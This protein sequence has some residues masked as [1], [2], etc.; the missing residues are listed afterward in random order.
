MQ[1]HATPVPA[2]GKLSERN[3]SY[4]ESIASNKKK[5]RRIGVFSKMGGKVQYKL[6]FTVGGLGLQ[7]CKTLLDAYELDHDWD[8]VRQRVF[9]DKS[10]QVRTES[11]A[12]RLIREY[13]SRLKNLNDEEIQTFRDGTRADQIAILSLS[14]CR[15]YALIGDFA[16]EVM[17]ERALSSQME[18]HATDFERFIDDK[19][20][21]HPGEL[22]PRVGFV[23]TT[24]T[25][26]V[27]RVFEFYNRRGTAV[28]YTKEG[29]YALKWTRLSCKS[30]KANEVRLQLHA[31]AYNLA[32]FLRSL[33]LPTSIADW[34]LMSLRDRMIKIGVKAVRH[35]RS[36]ILQLAEVA[37]TGQLWSQMLATIAGLKTKAQAP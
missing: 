15:T 9:D 2:A 6:S 3:K 13:V 25:V 28:Q 20:E 24:L 12:K 34:S 19:A 16:I 21:W 18:V 26:P 29:K 31:L 22:F 23:V 11:G 33:V 27:E 35:A 7:E 30:L 10:L 8:V 14:A 32:N 36:I 17:N 37:V 1:F 5:V 4:D